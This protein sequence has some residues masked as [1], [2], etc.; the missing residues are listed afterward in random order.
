MPATSI[1]SPFPIFTDIDGQPLE[2]GQ[3][4]LGTA[5]NNPIS[6]PITAYWDAA[7]T[8]VVTQPVTTRGGYPL[9]GTAVGRLYV[10]A[11]FSILVRNRRGYD[12]LSALSATERF[13]SSL[14]T[15][16]Q[17]GLGAVVRTA[18]A[19]MRDIVSV[20]DFGAVGD[21]VA[22][23]TA[24]IQAALDT[25]KSVYFP[26]GVYLVDSLTIPTAARGSTYY[27]DGY[28]H[29]NNNQKTVIKART[30]GQASI[31]T[32]A[33][34]ADNIT[35]TLMRIDGDLKAT[36]CV[37]ASF[38]AFLTFVECGV[39]KGTAYGVYSKQGLMRIDRCF[40]SETT[41]VQCHMWS[42]SSATDSEFSGGTVS[43]L[44]AAGG[45]RI[46]NI[47]AN[48]STNAC[49]AL[50]PF[51]NSTNHINTS[52][53]NL[54]AGEVLNVNRPV[55]D[56]VGTSA[57]RV[58]QVHISNS[59]IVTAVAASG[60]GIPT[61]IDGGIYMEYCQD[62]ALNNIQFRGQGLGATLT[63]YTPWGV[64]AGDNA[65]GLT[66]NAC[67]FRDINRNPIYLNS[68]IG[69]V[70]ITGCSFQDWDIDENAISSEAAAIRISSGRVSVTG[71]NFFIGGGKTQPYVVEVANANMIVLDN[72][73]MAMP[74]PTLQAGTG[75]IS[76]FN[77]FS[78]A[79]TYVGRNIEIYESIIGSSTVNNAKQN[80]LSRG[81]V[82]A[83]G[84][85]TTALTTLSSVAE[86]QS[87]LITVR[88]TGSG[89]NSVAAY[90]MAFSGSA[91]AVR[92]AQSN[93]IVALDMNITMSGLTIQ[94]VLGSGFGLA[95][96]DWVV[97]RL[98]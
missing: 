58:Q 96:W 81:Q 46:V 85:S 37:D 3:V 71:N 87:Y 79:N 35:F 20:K 27:G 61:K 26:Q 78:T 47:W 22:D 92:I 69:S 13:D 23:D 73:Y 88:Q 18:Q 72:N 86:D 38:G 41:G 67:T 21:G 40:M 16:V 70:S 10:N 93:T 44:L 60:Y 8:Q 42:D 19:K 74:T 29:Y 7:L 30:L 32:L 49:V 51:D 64:F 31:F 5:G 63:S 15:F 53:V 12:V 17:A 28:Y 95:T 57:N 39:Y 24:A 80:F 65:D 56:I 4:W 33:S 45:N 75:I 94:L 84:S 43:L 76:G 59:F 34:G 83:G 66:I 9:N 6:S 1:Q 52:I 90:V 50:R 77:R 36:R 89:N 54:Y 68:N 25:N 14:V 48:S 55:I 2:Q 62:I 82:S 98:G 11:D 97:T 91:E